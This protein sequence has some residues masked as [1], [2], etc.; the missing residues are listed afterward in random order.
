MKQSTTSTINEEVHQPETLTPDEAYNLLSNHANWE[1]YASGD[2]PDEEYE[3]FTN[4]IEMATEALYAQTV[5]G[6]NSTLY[7]KMF[8]SQEKFKR[9]LM[10]QPSEKILETAYEYVKRED[11]LSSL[12]YNDLEHDEVVAMLSLE[13]PLSS[14]FDW[15]ENHLNNTS[16]TDIDRAWSA[17]ED[18]TAHLL[19]SGGAEV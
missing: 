8:E 13:D 7:R 1:S 16:G 14:A 9:G 2:M 19:Q 4:A 6:L 12:E 10:L 3:Q 18:L 5:E 15:Y 11:L 17:I